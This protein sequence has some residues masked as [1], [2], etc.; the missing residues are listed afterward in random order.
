MHGGKCDYYMGK[1]PVSVSA[2]PPPLLTRFR[3]L[4]VRVTNGLTC[5]SGI[6]MHT[7]WMGWALLQGDI[8][9]SKS[10]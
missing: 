6:F 5:S 4:C 7:V 10:V 2:P 8:A 9:P 3:S 1:C